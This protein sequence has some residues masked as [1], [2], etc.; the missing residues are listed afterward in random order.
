MRAILP[1]TLERAYR[2]RFAP[3][4]VDLSSSAPQPLTARE[5]LEEAGAGAVS[6]LDER[7]DYEPGGGSRALRE[8]VASLYSNVSANQ[9][10]ITAGAAEAIRVVIE[11]AIGPG[12]RVVMQRP[13][14]Q[15]LRTAAK[16]RGA[17]VLDWTPA[18]GFQFDF[19]E[20]PA[21]AGY[22]S[23]VL[24]NNP[25]GPSGSLVRGSYASPARLIADEVYRPA[26]LIAD[27]RAPSMIDEVEGAVSIGDL[28]KPLGLGGLR[29]GWIV[30]RD[31]AFIAEC[32][33]VLDYFSA[34]VSSLSARVALAAISR[35]DVH[36]QRQRSRA[37][38][39]M[40]TLTTFV[41]QHDAWIDWSPPQAGYTA[42]PRLIARISAEE[43]SARMRARHVFL[44][45][46][47]VFGSPD[48]I[49]IGFGLESVSFAN[50]LC[51]LGEEL[52][53]VA[54]A[55]ATTAAAGDVILLAKQPLAGHA[56]TRLAADVGVERAAEFCGAF[57]RDSLD[58]ATSR[59]RRLYIAA[60]PPESLGL[61]R[62]LAPGAGCFAQPDAGFGT[63]LL[64]A[65]ETA[66]GDG[67]QHPVLIGT[68]SPT[69]PS[70]LLSVA[71]RA[72]ATHDVV[73]GPAD[74]GGYYLFGMNASHPSLFEGI[75]WSM[76]RVLSQTLARARAAGL[77]VFMLP[78]WYDVDDGHDLERLTSDPLLREH[79]RRA[80]QSRRLD[81]VVA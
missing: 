62:S 81:E 27:H 41:E 11:A 26:S 45:D 6:L 32:G 10:L 20:L 17:H 69:L 74:D 28:S 54:P 66:L 67:A 29:I 46:G 38:T 61:F 22:A 36:L 42:F 39:N 16:A 14:Y 52:R 18:P 51:E 79:T 47:A 72:L 33:A 53:A 19:A 34:S 15:A 49:R 58:V 57:V 65:F 1:F 50:A 75:D 31:R 3:G 76:D 13:L 37:R 56:K 43:L 7:L 21:E 55:A 25:H 68:D 23:A 71:Q 64:H 70:H 4:M 24:L 59:A 78:P 73:L 35:F 77:S 12:D 5:V 8:A 40:A 60:S 48:H 9:V 80:L 30:S 44:L 63:R 2:E